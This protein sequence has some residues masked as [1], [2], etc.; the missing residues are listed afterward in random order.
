MTSLRLCSDWLVQSPGHVRLSQTPWTSAHQ[1]SLSFTISQSL[2]K[3]MS[4]ESVIP[5]TILYSVAPFCSCPQ[6]SPASRSFPVYWL[7][8]SGG[9]TIGASVSALVLPM[10]IQGWYPLEL[11][12]LIS[13]Q[14]KGLSRVFSSPTVRKHQFFSA[15]P[16]LLSSSHIHTWLLGTQLRGH[17][18]S[19]L[20]H[21]GGIRISGELLKNV[22]FFTLP[23]RFWFCHSSFFIVIKY[24]E[25]KIDHFNHF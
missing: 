19:W 25:W 23:P 15:L 10:N 21:W 7:F 11:T 13:L 5:S 20:S 24:T 3:L 18:N 4:T 16:S 12:G 6:S 9:Q 17:N 8:V 14:S 2:L 1:A 22:S